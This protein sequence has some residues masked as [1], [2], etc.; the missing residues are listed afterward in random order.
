MDEDRGN[1]GRGGPLSRFGPRG[2]RENLNGPDKILR[3]ASVSRGQSAERSEE[4]DDVA[5]RGAAA[6]D[7]VRQA[8]ASIRA[9]ENRLHE[10][11]TRGEAL[12]QRAIKEL[13]ETET[14]VQGLVS[15]LKSAEVRAQ[16]M[17]A[18]WQEN[19]ARARQAE[20]WLARLH[21]AI[22]EDL[23]SKRALEQGKAGNPAQAG[24]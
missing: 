24:L 11:E 6:I 3:L 7:L 5:R 23:A 16:V 19:E 9:T 14:R 17:E 1:S 21:Q 13:R 18:R 20:E 4:G 10:T 12:V 15:R 8:A 2:R 22:F